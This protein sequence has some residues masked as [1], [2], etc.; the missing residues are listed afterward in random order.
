MREWDI[1]TAEGR[2]ELEAYVMGRMGLEVRDGLFGA[3]DPAKVRKPGWLYTGDGMVEAKR[4][5]ARE[6]GLRIYSMTDTH[7][8]F[9]E[10]YDFDVLV[11]APDEPT[12]VARALARALAAGEEAAG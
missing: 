8:C 5:A 10:G 11:T 12:A 1:S 2:A 6:K 9:A 3:R 7:M 4:W